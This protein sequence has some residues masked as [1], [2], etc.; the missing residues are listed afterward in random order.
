MYTWDVY[1]KVEFSK[2]DLAGMGFAPTDAAVATQAA[3]TPATAPGTTPAAA[4]GTA[5]SAEL[6]PLPLARRRRANA[7][8]GRFLDGGSRLGA[9]LLLRDMRHW[10]MGAAQIG[11]GGV[12][13]ALLLP[14]AVTTRPLHVAVE[15][16]GEHTRGMTV[17]DL[18][19]FSTPPDRP[20][21]APNAD[22]CVGVDGG[23]LARLYAERVLCPD[24]ASPYAQWAQAQG[25]A[26]GQARAAGDAAVATAVPGAIPGSSAAA[27]LAAE[28]AAVASQGKESAADD[29]GGPGV[30][31]GT[32]LEIASV[33]LPGGS[34]N[35]SQAWDV[36]ALLAA[37]VVSVAAAAMCSAVTARAQ[38]IVRR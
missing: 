1:L 38:A 23:R 29:S 21:L 31:A 12:V 3:A 2:K 13:G 20:I 27:E 30:G 6:R 26:Q 22:V 10:G 37:G 19:L 4:P 9:R 36:R 25:Q 8:P 28:L 32:R 7:L 11:D 18:R 16:R 34:S 5:L 14:G 24:P 15:L 33:S 35:A 17:A